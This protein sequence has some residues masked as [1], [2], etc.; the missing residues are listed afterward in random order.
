MRNLI[1]KRRYSLDK[2][3]MTIGFCGLIVCFLWVI[4][5]VYNKMVTY[6]YNVIGT[7][8]SENPEVAKNY[9]YALF[10]PMSEKS[11]KAGAEALS[12][13]GVTVSGT[14]DVGSELGIDRAVWPV[15]FVAFVMFVMTGYGLWKRLQ[16]EKQE[17]QIL[18]ERI[19]E[20]E[21]NQ[22]EE[23]F[24]A[25]QN[26]KIQNFIENIAHQIKTPISRVFS[27]LYIMEKSLEQA[28]LKVRLEECYSHLESVS[29]LMKR[30]MDIGRLEAGKVIFKK[31][32]FDFRL[33]LEEVVRNSCDVEGR[34]LFRDFTEG[35]LM[36]HGDDEWLG[37]ALKN[38]IK[39]GLE[40]DNSGL[41][42]EI[43]CEKTQE[44]IKVSIR[45]H[46][47]GLCQKD[48]P[49]LFDRFYIPAEVKANHTG[50]GL[51]LA[52]LIIEGHFGV[53]YVY[54]HVEGGAVFNIVL[55]LYSLK[56]GKQAL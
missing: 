4:W 3:L 18:L 7:L 24:L 17:K 54:N 37:E 52:K 39:N 1:E 8:Y 32:E 21:K 44:Q 12:D 29:S 51:N 30:L 33:L 45:D 25:K 31:E 11:V 43:S 34:I 36:Y 50:I 6:Q 9:L 48:I 20:M 41:P 26:Q 15:F 49:N 55:P 22:S 2:V 46:G 38:I 14:G 5:G 35:N 19:Q 27:S 13:F 53:I 47:P 42:L 28:E 16:R 23:D 40:H 10:E 56:T